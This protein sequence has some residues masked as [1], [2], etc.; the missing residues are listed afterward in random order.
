MW[1]RKLMLLAMIPTA[2]A[3]CGT[4]GSAEGGATDDGAQGRIRIGVP[5]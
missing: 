1:F 4:T 3:A 2:L 5:F